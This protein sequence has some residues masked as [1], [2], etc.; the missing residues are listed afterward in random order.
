[1]SLDFQFVPTIDRK[2]I[3]YRTNEGELHWLPRAEAFVWFQMG[4]Q[5]NLTGEMTTKKLIE[6]DRRIR[7]LNLLNR[8]PKYWD[9]DKN[10][11]QIQLHDVITYW[12]LTTNVPHLNKQKW[13]QYYLRMCEREAGTTPVHQLRNPVYEVYDCENK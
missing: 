11:Y 13:N 8:Y 5:H 3:E 10:G 1:M 7:L 4:L 6:I 12:G 9:A 2:L